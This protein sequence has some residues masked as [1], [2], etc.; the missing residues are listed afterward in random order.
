MAH[1]L[2]SPDDELQQG[3]GAKNTPIRPMGPSSNDEVPHPL[4]DCGQGKLNNNVVSNDRD[5]V[6]SEQEG[7][8]DIS[9]TSN[10]GTRR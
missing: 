3:A 9:R 8:R 7:G 10:G 5:D 2:A 4:M 6:A 1:W